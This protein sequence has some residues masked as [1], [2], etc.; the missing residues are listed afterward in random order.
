MPFDIDQALKAGYTESEVA[1]YLAGTRDFDLAGARKAGYTDAEIVSHFSGT[2]AEAPAKN[3]DFVMSLLKAAPEIAGG[4][5][6]AIATA[7][8]STPWGVAGAASG[9]IGGE[10]LLQAL[11]AGFKPDEAPKSFME[12]LSRQ[13]GAGLRGA[14][15]EGAGRAVMGGLGLLGK[16]VNRAAGGVTSKFRKAR[17]AKLTGEDAESAKLLVEE[18]IPHS[19]YDTTRSTISGRLED[20]SEK[21]LGSR[22]IM[23]KFHRAKTKAVESFAKK[24]LGKI[25]PKVQKSAIGDYAHETINYTKK[26]LEDAASQAFREAE[27]LAGSADLI[28]TAP[29]KA[30]AKEVLRKESLATK[31][32]KFPKLEAMAE[33]ALDLPERI[34]YERARELGSRYGLKNAN[35]LGI[36]EGEAKMLYRGMQDSVESMGATQSGPTIALAKLKQAKDTFKKSL[37]L[38]E[39][40][41][42]QKILNA[43]PERVMQ[44][45]FRKG[46][47]TEIKTL[48]T[49]VPKEDWW[50]FQREAADELVG[51]MLNASTSKTALNHFNAIGDDAIKATY[52]PNQIKI[53]NKIRDVVTSSGYH[54]SKSR[55]PSRAGFNIINI[56]QGGMAI[57]MLASALPLSKVGQLAF[58]LSPAA[59]AKV[60]THQEGAKLLLEGMKTPKTAK[61]AAG[62]VARIYAIANEKERTDKASRS[63]LESLSMGAKTGKRDPNI[64]S[65]L[66]GDTPRLM[67]EQLGGARVVSP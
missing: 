31:S 35:L 53:L 3:E 38:G 51:K 58:V 39:D 7:G 22:R 15:G 41:N 54:H 16:G 52:S 44:T 13:A 4:T 49:I 48:K 47:L 36:P 12:S 2:S 14:V 24:G 10:I 19:L 43:N 25:G 11:Q 37:E 27:V 57:N 42:L 64:E 5:A 40:A 50:L 30:M 26:Q 33:E 1:E 32:L 56:T 66:Q 55:I 67:E 23:E 18:G 17:R 62:I 29:L 8:K 61:V 9:S 59:I 63:F 21:S 45:V 65:M 6:G 20:L 34:T 28:P 60:I 46:N